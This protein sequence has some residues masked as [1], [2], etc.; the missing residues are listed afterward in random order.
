LSEDVGFRG[1]L[2]HLGTIVGLMK[3][4]TDYKKF[5]RQLEEIA[6]IYGETPGLIDNPKDWEVPD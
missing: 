4:H 6:P 5:E 2:V 3:I 1:V